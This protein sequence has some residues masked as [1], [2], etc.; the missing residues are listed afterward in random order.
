MKKSMIF[1]R[2]V[3]VALLLLC[4]GLTACAGKK[5]GKPN[6]RTGQ[7]Q[8]LATLP[9]NLDPYAA[10]AGGNRA[11]ISMQ[12][13]TERAAAQ[14]ERFYRPWT[15]TAPTRWVKES[16]NKNF[17]LRPDNAYG[18]D[19]RP[20]SRDEWDRLVQ[21]SNKGAYPSQMGP[22]ITVHH[23]NLRAMPTT[24]HFFL[25]PERPGEG[26]PFD[27]FQHTSMPL[28]TPVF[29]CNVSKD[30]QWVLVETPV[31]AGWLPAAD[32]AM[33]DSAFVDRW[34][35]LPLAALVRD[36]VTVGSA[37]MAHIGTLLPAT[38]GGG[39]LAVLYPG[40]S[41]S[42]SAEILT[43]SLPADAVVR[44]PLPLT[45]QQVAKVGNEMMGQT[46]GWGGIDEKRDCSAL[47]RDLYAP[48]GIWLPRNSATQASSGRSTLLT[49]MSNQEKETVIL[50]EGVPF[51]SLVGLPGHIGVYLGNYNGKPVMFHDIWGLRIR[52][53]GPDG[54]QREGRLVIGKAVV[55]SLQPG[56]E[57]PNIST[58]GSLLDRVERV[59][60]LSSGN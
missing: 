41:A 50:T 20:F 47:T 1:T 3:V 5:A 31:S 16:L 46:Y 60:T 56:V 24:G 8:D 26:Y 2:S 38:G 35:G 54:N 39:S 51:L 9:Q 18:N 14:K 27:Y 30:G 13:Q 23:T 42:G 17:N 45:A 32:V 58:P 57:L 29:V 4:L 7:V 40:R 48:F 52:E 55:T 22:G 15:M 53:E 11:L 21:N 44:V 19:L 33:A 37:G 28:G 12:E 59:T 36:K 34:Q 6:Y 49:G 25:N 10:K 43:T